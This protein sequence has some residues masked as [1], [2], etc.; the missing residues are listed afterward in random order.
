MNPHEILD[1][2]KEQVALIENE[3]NKSS[4]A[5]QKRCRSCANTIKKLAADFKKVS[6]AE[7]KAE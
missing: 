7:S 6:T 5:A 3:I 2:I 1:A 4:K